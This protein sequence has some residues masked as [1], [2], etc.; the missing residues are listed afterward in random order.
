M[1]GEESQNR[2]PAE[3]ESKEEEGDINVDYRR[4]E[5]ESYVQREAFVKNKFPHSRRIIEGDDEEA[6]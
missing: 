6:L 1:E 3:E 5:A 4:P 2:Q